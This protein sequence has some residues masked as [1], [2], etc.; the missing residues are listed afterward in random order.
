VGNESHSLVLSLNSVK[1]LS[2]AVHCKWDQRGLVKRGRIILKGIKIV[3]ANPGIMLGH[4]LDDAR[5]AQPRAPAIPKDPMDKYH[6]GI[7]Q[8]M[9]IKP[10]RKLKP[11][12]IMERI[13][14]GIDYSLTSKDQVNTKVSFITQAGQRATR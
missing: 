3:A 11:R 9:S 12:R 14:G 2:Q 8:R 1:K 5:H 10:H 4:T 6:K 13:R 7:V